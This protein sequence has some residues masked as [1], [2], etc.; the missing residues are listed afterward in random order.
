MATTLKLSD[1]DLFIGYDGKAD[2]LTGI[3]KTAQDIACALLEFYDNTRNFGSDLDQ[4]EFP[5]RTSAIIMPSMIYQ[6]VDEAMQRLLRKQDANSAKITLDEQIVDYFVNVIPT[7][8]LQF[9][10]YVDA[11]VTE[12][13]TTK[14][15]AIVSLRH[16]IDEEAQPDL[17]GAAQAFFG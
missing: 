12:G 11:R 13:S 2:T 10:F 14:R 1:G 16:Q 4:L 17:P 15:A 8:N 3:D 7:G 9:L 5:L 6:K